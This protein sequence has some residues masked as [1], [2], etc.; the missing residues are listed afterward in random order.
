LDRL[1]CDPAVIKSLAGGKLSDEGPE[2][3]TGR[4]IANIYSH[5]HKNITN[6]L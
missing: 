1:G 3:K 5:L 4:F 6:A 2:V